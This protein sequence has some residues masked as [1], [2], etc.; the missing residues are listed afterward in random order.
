MPRLGLLIP[1]FPTQTHIAMWRLGRAIARAGVEVE[2][3]STRRPEGEAGVHPALMEDAGRTFYCWPSRLGGVVNEGVRSW[4]RLPTAM[5]YAMSLRQ[6]GVRERLRVLG[7]I[8]PALALKRRCRERRLG[9][10]FVHS[11]A[12]AAHL[13]ALTRIL[14]GPAYS[15]RL[16]GDIDV[17]GVNQ[18]AKM[19]R[20]TVVVGAARV[21]MQQAIDTARVP[22]DRAIWAW[23]GVETGKYRPGMH[24]ADPDRPMRLV[25]VARLNRAKGHRFVLDA[26]ALARTK[27]IEMHWTIVGDGPERAAIEDQVRALELEQQVEMTGSLDEDG[28]RASLQM[29]EVFVLPTSGPGEG[30]PVA[31][32]EAM[33]AGL[34]VV[35]SDVGGLREMVGEGEGLIVPPGDSGALCEALVMLARDVRR[36]GAMGR[37]SRERALREFD[38]DAVARRLVGYFFPKHEPVVAGP[39]MSTEGHSEVG[40]AARHPGGRAASG[41]RAHNAA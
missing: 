20:A 1:E 30:S 22:K 36:R 27:G 28:V 15:L 13:A 32:L 39:S 29:G 11:C 2:M 9:H 18:R 8:L 40:S 25:T 16:G 19:K 21:N 34:A 10:V 4:V 17:Y 12:S 5:C 14:G 41:E 35:A 23:L 37:A 38:V 7:I 33:S 24:A 26:L 3:L 31:V 6:G